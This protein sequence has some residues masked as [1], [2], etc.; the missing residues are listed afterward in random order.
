M[1]TQIL[2]RP[3]YMDEQH[4]ATLRCPGCGRTRV[5]DVTRYQNAPKPPKVKCACGH[6]FRVPIA[7]S[8][9]ARY[10]CQTCAGKGYLVIEQGKKVSVSTLGYHYQTLQSKEPCATCGGLGVCY[11][12]TASGGWSAVLHSGLAFLATRALA[13]IDWITEKLGVSESSIRPWL[14]MD[15]YTLGNMD[16][17]ALY[18]RKPLAGVRH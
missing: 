13:R 5:A 17:F 11:P 12:R 9:S 16:V 1:Q 2:Q 8:L 6:R 4:M 14:E 15:M 18:K 3:V 10:A 7:A